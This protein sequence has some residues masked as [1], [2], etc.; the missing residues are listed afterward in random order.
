M[1]SPIL[2]AVT[3][4]ESTGKSQLCEALAVH[5]NTVFVPEQA[6][7]YLEQLGSKWQYEDVL[8][9]ARLQQA[10]IEAALNTKHKVVFCDTELIAIKVWL[11]FYGLH[12]PQWVEDFIDNANIKHYLLMNIDLPWA[13]DPLRENPDPADRATLFNSFVT[14]LQ[15]HQKPY[16]IISG[17]ETARL[18]NAISV[19]DD[20]V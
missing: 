17:S 16:S 5:Y 9:I 8:Q 11:Q 19:V 6:R 1:T 4:P 18:R 20:L 13:S 10:A 15:Q 12:C 14:E 3:G 7:A 2:I